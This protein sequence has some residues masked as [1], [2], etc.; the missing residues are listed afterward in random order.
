MNWQQRSRKKYSAVPL[1]Q[2]LL[3]VCCRINAQKLQFEPPLPFQFRINRIIFIQD[4]INIQKIPDLEV[5]IQDL[6]PLLRILAFLQE[7]FQFA[8]YI[9]QFQSNMGNTFHDLISC[10]PF[11]RAD[12]L[13]LYTI[14]Q[15]PLVIHSA[16]GRAGFVQY[17][18]PKGHPI[19]HVPAGRTDF[20]Q[21]GIVFAFPLHLQ[22]Q[23][24]A[25]LQPFCQPGILC[26][27]ETPDLQNLFFIN[28]CAVHLP[29]ALHQIVRLIDQEQIAALVP[30]REKPFQMGIRIKYV[31]IIA[32]HPVYPYRDIQRHLKGA[33][34]ILLRLGFQYIA[35]QIAAVCDQ[36][37]HCVIDPVIVPLCIGAGIWVALRFLTETDFFLCSQGDGLK[38]QPL[39]SK[40]LECLFRNGSGDGFCCQ[41]K[42]LFPQFLSHGPYCGKYGR[43]RFPHPG[44]CLDK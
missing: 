15:A 44:R 3:Q 25:F 2:I 27:H 18:I 43:H 29:S 39:A 32:D 20:V 31:I 21:Y 40:C 41:V 11:C 36:V 26:F 7:T 23:P 33:D 30:L 13:I 10:I 5:K 38:Q 28:L 24:V 8:E 19:T 17:G 14:L 12:V 42:Q 4:V 34:P 37:E 6:L 9:H 16:A 1:F 35:C 22:K